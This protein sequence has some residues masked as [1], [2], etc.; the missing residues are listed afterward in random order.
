MYKKRL[1][2]PFLIKK[3]IYLDS[4]FAKICDFYKQFGYIVIFLI[5]NYQDYVN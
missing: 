4:W 3:K 5:F 2:K 1:L